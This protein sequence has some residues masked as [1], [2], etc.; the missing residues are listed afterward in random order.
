VIL[1]YNLEVFDSWPEHLVFIGQ[2]M[3]DCNI[4][5]YLECLDEMTV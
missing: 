1:N 2:V 4:S 3:S 5:E